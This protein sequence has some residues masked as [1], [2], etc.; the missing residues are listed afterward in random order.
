V[1]NSS[2]RATWSLQF[3]FSPLHSKDRTE[4]KKH[5]ER[6]ELAPQLRFEKFPRG[7]CAPMSPVPITEYFTQDRLERLKYPA[8]IAFTFAK[9]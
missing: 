5:S 9:M 2:F 4:G 8:A 3:R 7:R 6:S 1:T